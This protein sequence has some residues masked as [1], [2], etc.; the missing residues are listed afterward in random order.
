MRFIHIADVHLGMA[1][2]KNM[3]WSEVRKKE[4]WDSFRSIIEICNKENVDLLLI[5]GDLFHKQPLVRELKE[6]DYLFSTLEDTQVIMIA[7]NHDYIGPRSNYSG[8]KWSENVHMILSNSI[9]VIEFSQISTK[10]YGLSYITRDIEEN[11]YDYLKPDDEEYINILLAHGGDEKNAPINKRLLTESGFDYIALGHIHKPEIISPNMAYS[12][13]L[14]P[15]DRNEVG[16][17]GYIIGEIPLDEITNGKKVEER[18]IEF[19]P[20]S[21][22]QYKKVSITS[23]EGTTNGKLSDMISEVITEEGENNIY[24]FTI[25]G[26]RD[27]D[28]DFDLEPLYTLGNIVALQDITVRNYDFDQLY[29]DNK[30]NLIGL[31]IKE[32]REKND[33]IS[34]KA[35]HYGIDALLKSKGGN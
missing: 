6:V 2:D 32:M 20:S 22:R 1:P 17:R 3:L 33:V 24:S 16:E 19:I 28:I 15:L 30:Y 21:K 35:L 31:F 8:F 29:N 12:G 27:E 18:I 11:I 9:E 10:I 4:I 26:F 5:A 23:D 13:S 7:G 25:T 14:E 34:L